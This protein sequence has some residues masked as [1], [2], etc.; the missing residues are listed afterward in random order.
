MMTKFRSYLLVL[1]GALLL[2]A[3]TSIHA[4]AQVDISASLYGQFSS[5]TYSAGETEAPQAS[6][7]TLV[8][9]RRYV[10]PWLGYELTYSYARTDY[11]FTGNGTQVVQS[12]DQTFTADYLINMH[13]PVV[14]L[15]PFALA[16]VGATHFGPT[17]NTGA[18]SATKPVL[19]YGVGLDY[20]VLP[21]VGLRAQYRALVYKSPLFGTGYNTGA[22]NSSAE[23]S[24]GIYVHF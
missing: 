11:D 3:A 15:R 5:Q 20:R 12:H 21:Y 24:L 8:G 22:A 4:Q 23:P 16:G 17:G 6:I 10:H 19:A 13:I 2:T 14:G 9:V 18:T 1:A 7:G